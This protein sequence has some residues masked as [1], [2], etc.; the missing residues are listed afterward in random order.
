MYP[1]FSAKRCHAFRL[2]TQN[3]LQPFLQQGFLID[4]NCTFPISG[5]I[6]S[7]VPLLST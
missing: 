3:A 7:N 2:P 1:A 6:L 5:Q 4:C